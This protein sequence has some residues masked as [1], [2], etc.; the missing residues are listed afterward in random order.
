MSTCGSWLRAKRHR[1]CRW[2]CAAHVPTNNHDPVFPAT[3][4]GYRALLVWAGRFGTVRRA[5]V[6]CTGSY[7]AALA[8]HLRAAGVK[9]IEV[10]EP[11]KATRR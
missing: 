8:R 4:A 9:V 11:D 1:R 6:E 10:N 7:G 3:A 5:G 2:R